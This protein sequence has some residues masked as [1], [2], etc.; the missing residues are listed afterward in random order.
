MR[1]MHPRLPW[2][3]EVHRAFDTPGITLYD[4]LRTLFDELDKPIA[5]RDFWCQELGVEKRA[6]LTRAFKERCM[7]DGTEKANETMM[8]GVK[9][10]DFLW[11]DVVF[12]GLA[13]R[14]G[15][16]WEIKTANDL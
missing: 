4:V 11:P 16:V 9:R 15:G 6:E 10:V 2:Y 13:R 3:I 1:L 8:K 5:A 12:V 7:M 14:D